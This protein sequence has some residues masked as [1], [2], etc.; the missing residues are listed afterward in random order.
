MVNSGMY[1]MINKCNIEALNSIKMSPPLMYEIEKK[2]AE[3]QEFF[4]VR[5]G[6]TEYNKKHLYTGQ[7]D[8]PLTDEGQEQAYQVA[9]K[10]KH[11]SIQLIACSPLA[12]AKHTA[13]IIARCLSIPIVEIEGL[14]EFNMGIAQGKSIEEYRPFIKEW[15]EGKYL[16]G[17]EIFSEFMTRLKDGLKQ[18]LSLNGRVLI[19]SHGGIY[20]KI[21][22]ILEIP[23]TPCITNAVPL[24][25]YK[26]EKQ[27]FAVQYEPLCEKIKER[28]QRQLRIH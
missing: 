24:H 7:T 2:G 22:K 1:S 5:H 21:E 13:T 26:V 28:S 11:A 9:D 16:E 23:A 4:F 18:A 20:K 10:L 6:Q 8:I 3:S 14:K 27:W 15:E 12:R 25:L 17:A 19:V